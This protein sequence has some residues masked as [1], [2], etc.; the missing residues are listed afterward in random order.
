MANSVVQLKVPGGN[1]FPITRL[2]D[3]IDANSYIRRYSK[4][5]LGGDLDPEK[6]GY[7]DPGAQVTFFRYGPIV[8]ASVIIIVNKVAQYKKICTIP[9]G[10]HISSLGYAAM[11]AGNITYADS[12]PFTIQVSGSKDLLIITPNAVDRSTNVRASF[13]WVTDDDLPA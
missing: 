2:A 13:T 5:L 12:K 11:T 9:A 8:I 6:F 10:Y 3:A 7:L 4:T 1:A